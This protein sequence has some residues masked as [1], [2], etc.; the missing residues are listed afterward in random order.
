MNGRELDQRITI[1][2]AARSQDSIGN[3]ILTWQPW[4]TVWASVQTSG[5]TETFYS[6][7]V[8]AE[9]THKIKMRYLAGVVA[10]MRII[11][12]GRTL[13]ITH[14]DSSRQRQGE[15]YLICQEVVKS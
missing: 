7:Q 1:Q 15:L 14:V 3:E 10:A 12:K 5:G 8:L 11:W 2:V 6:A 4:Q 13:E 9:A